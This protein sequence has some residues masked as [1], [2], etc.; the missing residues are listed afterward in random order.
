MNDLPRAIDS[1]ILIAPVI[2]LS[3]AI[4]TANQDICTVLATWRGNYSVERGD[5]LSGIARRF[6]L[7]V[8]EL[9]AGKCLD[10]GAWIIVGQILSIP[11]TDISLENSQVTG[12]RADTYVLTSGMCTILRWDAVNSVSI[13]L[14]DIPVSQN[15]S[16]EVCPEET[17]TY[18]LSIR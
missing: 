6:N 13:L 3:T 1:T 5:T 11:S 15:D 8:D 18:T 14:D 2:S 4:P 7:T 17:Q 12:F 10:N 9:Q 16:L